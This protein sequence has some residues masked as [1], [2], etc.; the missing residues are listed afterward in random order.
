[1]LFNRTISHIFV[2]LFTC[3]FLGNEAFATVKKETA[4]VEDGAF[5]EY[6]EV[7]FAED[8]LELGRKIYERGLVDRQ[9][10]D[11]RD[12]N[13]SLNG[14]SIEVRRYLVLDA[15]DEGI[16]QTEFKKIWAEYLE[17]SDDESFRE[18]EFQRF[19]EWMSDGKF[20]PG[21]LVN[22]GSSFV[23]EDKFV[24]YAALYFSHFDGSIGTAK[25]WD[26]RVVLGK[27]SFSEF[28]SHAWIVEILY[29]RSLTYY[30]TDG[31]SLETVKQGLDRYYELSSKNVGPGD[32]KYSSMLANLAFMA[33]LGGAPESAA[34]IVAWAGEFEPASIFGEM[35]I[36]LRK[37][38]VFS[39]NGEFEKALIGIGK[40][41]DRLES[42]PTDSILR[43][44]T[45]LYAAAYIHAA[46]YSSVL[47]LDSESR[48]YLKKFDST[49]MP[50]DR[51]IY[52]AITLF[53]LNAGI[54]NDRA[55]VTYGLEL[56]QLFYNNSRNTSKPGSG[57]R[58]G[59]GA[60]IS[61]FYRPIKKKD[62]DILFQ[63]NHFISE[64]FA[65][66]L[67]L[68]SQKLSFWLGEE[69][70][71]ISPE[72]RKTLWKILEDRSDRELWEWAQIV[73]G[74]DRAA[75]YNHL[76]A[77]IS[78]GISS[79]AHKDNEIV[80]FG[81]ASNFVDENYEKAYAAVS[82]LNA[83]QM[84]NPLSFEYGLE[85]SVLKMIYAF[86]E[87]D[88]ISG[89]GQF[90][91]IQ[92]VHGSELG[93]EDQAWI[94]GALASGLRENRYNHAAL[95]ISSIIINS[96]EWTEIDVPSFLVPLHA[97]LLLENGE[98][99][100]LEEYMEGNRS[101]V[102]EFSDAADLDSIAL[103]Y[104][105]FNE[106]FDEFNTV[107][108]RFYKLGL[109]KAEN[110]KFLR[111][112]VKV[113]NKVKDIRSSPNE[114]ILVKSGYSDWESDLKQRG[115]L[116]KAAEA[117][118]NILSQD[119]S[120]GILEFQS[121]QSEFNNKNQRLTII[122]TTMALLSLLLAT[123]LSRAV[124]KTK[125]DRIRL[126]EYSEK[127]DELS[128]GIAMAGRLGEYH[129][130]K[131]R[132]LLPAGKLGED[133]AALNA[134]MDQIDSVE[135]LWSDLGRLASAKLPVKYDRKKMSGS[136][137]ARTINEEFGRHR[138]SGQTELRIETAD[139]KHLFVCERYLLSSA[140]QSVMKFMCLETPVGEITAAIT[141]EDGDQAY[142]HMKF[143]DEG[144]GTSVIKAGIDL[145][146]YWNMDGPAEVIGLSIMAS[147][148]EGKGGSFAHN[149]R[150]GSGNEI[151][152]RV[153]IKITGT[154]TAR[155]IGN[156]NVVQIT[157]S[158]S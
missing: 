148:I 114:A 120:Q 130:G 22:T 155:E 103:L 149:A 36:E 6:N 98:G 35:A 49:G 158:S 121:A 128:S 54:E 81:A 18:Q 55:R 129:S 110:T 13:W 39:D 87:G 63:S 72:F 58:F 12:E 3:L 109:D 53:I 136:F 21:H 40:V 106:S 150:I 46:Y 24:Q 112:N 44:H 73:P 32:F 96:P 59:S 67:R 43:E 134:A 75:L 107:Y 132:K 83:R 142:L 84:R 61:K 69:T 156:D 97:Q 20:A 14:E 86:R 92:N 8:I 28:D 157:A 10:T 102:I 104:S 99:E 118:R 143:K 17:L 101:R 146:E 27:L 141:V 4:P 51:S 153:P 116:Y 147:V 93:F 71:R 68:S 76:T 145:E 30:I 80:L 62:I 113:I 105:A 133:D 29:A 152:L 23:S 38:S 91:D 34:Q 138:S 122:M 60:S 42:A 77:G 100:L 1:M 50:A 111:E 31:G 94:G 88:V 131:I 151:E 65:E 140:V 64:Q 125:Q 123:L 85:L 126:A 74:A 9:R 33:Q 48:S 56:R 26:P 70:A 52:Y 25:Q 115:S 124:F 137:V 108:A 82:N 5:A 135:T 2:V 89:L 154:K 57:L 15:M 66:E 117:K 37:N 144:M 45:F 139:Q 79:I 127:I 95:K 7:P 119:L 90:N 16:S 47:G 41:I 78:D 11:Y 19:L